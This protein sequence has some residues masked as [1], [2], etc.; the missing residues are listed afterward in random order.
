MTAAGGRDRCLPLCTGLDCMGLLG[1]PDVGS[2][3]VGG[4]GGGW[5]CSQ[6]GEA[7]RGRW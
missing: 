7:G 2:R 6:E 5:G 4:W 1:H 3:G